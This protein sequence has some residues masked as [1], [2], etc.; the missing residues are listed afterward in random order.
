MFVF[1]NEVCVLVLCFVSNCVMVLRFVCGAGSDVLF[2][3]FVFVVGFVVSFEVS[4]LV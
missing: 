1:F 3:L 4:V 2:L